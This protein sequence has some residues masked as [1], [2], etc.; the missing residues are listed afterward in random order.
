MVRFIFKGISLIKL[1]AISI[2]LLNFFLVLFGFK[3]IFYVKL[4]ANSQ[5]WML[6]CPFPYLMSL[7]TW[8]TPFGVQCS[9][10][11]DERQRV[12]WGW[13]GWT[14]IKSVLYFFSFLDILNTLLIYT[15]VCIKKMSWQISCGFKNFD[16]LGVRIKKIKNT[17]LVGF[18]SNQSKSNKFCRDFFNKIDGDFNIKGF[19]N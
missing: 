12:W 5:F 9:K 18:F 1:N 8:Q 17:L 16:K 19:S 14:V 3:A 13:T 15:Y 4:K 10:P 11:Y 2:F 7:V 6:C